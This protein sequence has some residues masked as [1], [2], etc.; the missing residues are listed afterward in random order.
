M[1]DKILTNEL[2]LLR[3]DINENFIPLINSNNK[4]FEEHIS[5]INDIEKI[6]KKYLLTNLISKKTNL[7]K[8]E[9]K[10][11]KLNRV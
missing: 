5:I 2:I 1:N 7:P 6:L 8:H 3:K 9:F 4:L 10:S 11:E